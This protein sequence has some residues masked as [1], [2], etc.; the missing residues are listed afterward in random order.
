[1]IDIITSVFVDVN[2]SK[3]QLTLFR[4][5]NYFSITSTVNAYSLGQILLRVEADGS[6]K[7]S[8]NA[9][10]DSHWSRFDI[11][12]HGIWAE[13]NRNMRKWF[14]VSWWN[15]E[16]W[17][18]FA[19]GLERFLCHF[20]QYGSM[21]MS[22]LIF[23]C[24]LTI[25]IHQLPCLFRIAKAVSSTVELVNSVTAGSVNPSVRNRSG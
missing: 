3:A 24:E 20:C 2:P 9:L 11:V 16:V 18:S 14:H 13:T 25:V 21:W 1:M 4:D 5:G 7:L 22:N 23:L 6:T 17:K 19:G 15:S 10:Y 12:F 8:R